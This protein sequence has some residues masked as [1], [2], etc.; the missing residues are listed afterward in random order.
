[1][2]RREFARLA[3]FLTTGAAVP[4]Y[5]EATL[6]QDIKAI[7]NLPP[8]VVRLNANENP[9]G[10]CPAA[11]EAIDRL[12]PQ[13]GRYLFDQGRGFALALA[14]SEGLPESHVMATAGSSDPLHRSVLSF[15]SPTRPLVTANPG[16]EAPERAARFMGA[17]VFQVPLRKDH[18]HDAQAMAKADA[19][20][21]VI[22]VCNPNNPTGTITRKE[23]IDYL[24]AN[25]PKGCVVVID[26]AYIH[27][28]PAATPATEHVAAGKEVIVL[29]TFSKIYGM[30]GLRCGAALAHPGLLEKLRE[31]GGL[32]M[33]P[34][35][36]MAGGIA[37]LKDKDL[38]PTRRKIV[39]DIREDLF[40]WLG[41]KGYSFIPSEANMVMIDGKKPGP[42]TAA[43]MLK[44]KVAIGRAWPS[45]PNHVRVTIGTREE[46]TKF[47]A[48]FERVT[49]A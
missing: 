44:H 21:G 37:S 13:T 8:D 15:T 14:A 38:V 45:L 5:N 12:V 36:G 41:K 20:A 49:E 10:P 25:K 19:S 39:K 32:G 1:L 43:D 42:Q 28:T 34:A 6:A 16:Y 30:A 48:G 46:M 4:F 18:S 7:A 35:T 33:L 31:W 17:K 2:T 27:F 22:Y 11:I 23:D 24:I 9:M 3:A 40:A 26:E 29:R 47:K